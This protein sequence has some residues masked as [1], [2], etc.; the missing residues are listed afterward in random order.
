[1]IARRAFCELERFLRHEKGERAHAAGRA[2][3]IAAMALKHFARFNGA[4][5]TNR[6][7]RTA[8]CKR[9]FHKS[10]PGSVFF[11]AFWVAVRCKVEL[12]VVFKEC[13]EAGE[14]QREALSRVGGVLH[15]FISSTG[16]AGL[17]DTDKCSVRKN[18]KLPL[19]RRRAAVSRPLDDNA[20]VRL[21]YFRG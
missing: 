4:F 8:A 13:F 11:A 5:V 7:A 10:F 18:R 15:E 19:H 1:M 12:N 16:P 20:L 17:R 3:A 9:K 2:L 14:H 6:P 21:D